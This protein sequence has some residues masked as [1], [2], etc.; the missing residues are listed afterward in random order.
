ML[1]SYKHSQG[2]L[3]PTLLVSTTV[4]GGSVGYYKAINTY[5]LYALTRVIQPNIVLVSTTVN[6]VLWASVRL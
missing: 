1:I 5:K 4:N 6:V 2:S 3:G